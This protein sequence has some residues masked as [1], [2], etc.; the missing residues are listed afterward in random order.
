MTFLKNDDPQQYLFIPNVFDNIGASFKDDMANIEYSIFTLSK[1]KDVRHLEYNNGGVKISIVPNSCGLPTIFDKDILIYC[2]V[3][4]MTEINAGRTPPRTFRVSCH[5]L[6]KSTH[7][8]IN[9]DGYKLLKKALDRLAG[10]LIKTSRYEQI[11]VFDI[12]ES[13]DIIESHKVKNRM[14]RLEI[15]LSEWL[16]N[17]ILRKEVLTISRDYFLLGKPIE[18]R[19]YEIARKHCGNSEKWNIGLEK[20]MAKVG[21]IGTL[22]LFRSRLKTII[23]DN[24]LPNYSLSLNEKDIVTFIS[25]KQ[26]SAMDKL[27][28]SIQDG[29]QKI[30]NC[31]RFTTFEKA[32]NLTY[33]SRTGWD[34]N[35]II[36]QFCDFVRSKKEAGEAIET[37]NGA[38]LG[39]VKNKIKNPA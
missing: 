10:V 29:N 9:G 38:F 6:L 1:K 11:H 15:T 35:A 23:K 5:N 26:P 14:V 32:R 24:N 34:F 4:L 19:L 7:R 21:S 25:Q 39:F 37:Y 8:S 17:S 16:Y 13:Y 22:R 2:T 28:L 3:L 36:E 12:L 31:I 18:R 33:Q 30:I 27:P 20:L